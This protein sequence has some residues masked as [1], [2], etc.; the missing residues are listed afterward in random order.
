VTAQVVAT[1][2][3]LTGSLFFVAGSVVLLW[4]ALS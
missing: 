2:L 1:I 3:Y 4:K